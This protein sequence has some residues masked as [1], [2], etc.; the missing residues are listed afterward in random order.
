MFYLQTINYTTYRYSLWHN[1]K[2]VTSGRLFRLAWRRRSFLSK[3][4]II[5]TIWKNKSKIILNTKIG[6]KSDQMAYQCDTKV[7][8]GAMLS[9]RQHITYSYNGCRAGGASGHFG[10]NWTMHKGK[11]RHRVMILLIVHD[12]LIKFKVVRTTVLQWNVLIPDA[13]YILVE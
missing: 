2:N 3:T 10:D 6:V 8:C 13:I 11:T 1:V 7:N 9:Q 4:C 5:K 12:V